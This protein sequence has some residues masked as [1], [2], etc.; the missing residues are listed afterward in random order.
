MCAF[1]PPYLGKSGL[2]GPTM[3]VCSYV[4]SKGVHYIVLLVMPDM[5]HLRTSQNHSHDS[6]M[7]YVHGQVLCSYLIW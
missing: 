6:N 3:S 7:S 2:Y 4:M 5:E 1:T